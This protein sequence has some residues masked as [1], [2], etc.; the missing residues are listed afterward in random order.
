MAKIPEY[1]GF[2]SATNRSRLSGNVQSNVGQALVGLGGAVSRLDGVLEADKQRD[3]AKLEKSLEFGFEKQLLDFRAGQDE[4]LQNEFKEVEPGAIGFS[5]KR[6]EA[7][8]AEAESLYKR[9]PEHLKERAAL[10]LQQ[11]TK[12]HEFKARGLQTQESE[13]YSRSV[14][15]QS[16]E[17]LMSEVYADPDS[18]GDAIA[19]GQRL[20]ETSGL[21]NIEK[22]ERR[23]A[24][25]Q[26]AVKTLAERQLEDDP[27][28]LISSLSLPESGTYT[29]DNFHSRHYEWT[30]FRN[31]R[32]KDAEMP[33]RVVKAL[34]QVT[35]EFGKKLR[36][37]SG[38]R[39]KK[40]NDKVSFSKDSRH[41]HGDAIDIDLNGLPDNEKARAVSLFVKHG[42]V[43]VGHYPDGS[44]HID[45]RQEEGKGPGG[46]ALWYGKNKAYTSGKKWFKTG[47]EVGLDNRTSV[48]AV[49]DSRYS[50]LGLG[51]RLK[52]K[53]RASAKIA[54]RDRLYRDALNKQSLAASQIALIA[55]ELGE[56][57][58]EGVSERVVNPEH[59]LEIIRRRKTLAKEQRASFKDRSDAETQ[60][61][62]DDLELKITLGEIT[63]KEEILG[64]NIPSKPQ[65]LLIEALEGRQGDFSARALEQQKLLARRGI[66][67]DIEEASRDMTAEDTNKLLTFLENEGK[68]SAVSDDKFYTD[69]VLQAATDPDSFSQL[70]P[71]DWREKLDKK[72]F[73]EMLK[74]QASILKGEGGQTDIPDVSKLRS[75]AQTA[76]AAAGLDKAQEA[77]VERKLVEWAGL[78][79]EA[80]NNPVELQKQVDLMLTEVSLNP[81]GFWMGDIEGR[82]FDFTF[83]GEKTKE[84]TS[85]DAQEL[86]GGE[87]EF[88]GRIVPEDDIREFI[89]SYYASFGF[90][91]SVDVILRGLLESGV[92]R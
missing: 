43:G 92:Y 31:E 10:V 14:L 70:N 61:V 57:P 23:K 28:G 60:D 45:F 69:L 88:N 71:L 47:I 83:G 7:Y 73:R 15:D 32:F 6:L 52:L 82:G 54:Q 34:D 22:D 5:D 74:T 79:P 25:E 78:N 84:L 17:K 2:N 85:L 64:Y 29:A 12:K 37:T 13:R 56:E 27:E 65:R 20:I 16:V 18:I 77:K 44:V 59:Q 8:R 86:L 46:L 72:D 67:L 26:K 75:A 33:A 38:Y 40:H 30:D 49:G 42:A 19:D 35:D 9:A 76:I 66:D 41:S 24:L 53:D 87:L 11:D 36:I 90:E 58:P 63:T 21:S 1:N 4:A 62:V 55:L 51:P 89:A 3:Q 48:A 50:S 81:Y 80:A 39:S 91:P 68:T